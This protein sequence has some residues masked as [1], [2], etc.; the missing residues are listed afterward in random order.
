METDAPVRRLT[1]D[2]PAGTVT[3]F[4]SDIEGSTQLV[5]RLGPD[6]RQVL[7]RHGSIVREGLSRYGGI[8]IG[9][10]GDSFFAVFE[11]AP[12][13]VEATIW[14]QHALAE[15]PW[16]DMG[17]VRVRI[18]LH[19][20]TA[21]IGHD[22]YI[23]LDV[24]RGARISAAGHGG[25]AL[26]STTTRALA[27]TAADFL[28]LGDFYLKDLE[29]P[30]R[31][32]QI[33]IP[34]LPMSFPPIRSVGS[35]RNNL[36]ASTSTLVGR[37]REMAEISDLLDQH[38]LVT[39]SGPGGIGKT[40]L[41][42]EIARQQLPRYAHGV[43]MVD[44]APV[45]DER[46]VLP[47]IGNSIGV[48]DPSLTG[49][50]GYLGDDPTLLFIDNFE[51]VIKASRDMGTMLQ[52]ARG[53]KILATSQLPLRI[54]GERLYRLSPLGTD[55]S[56]TT[57]GSDAAKLFADRAQAVD[58]SFR[59]EDHVHAVENLV[60]VL[61]GLPLAVELAAAR[62]NLMS[63]TEIAKRLT[64][65]MGLLAGGAS[66]APER[67]RSVRAAIKWSYDLLAP[68]SQETLQRLSQFRGGMTLDAAETVGHIGTTD[69]L[70]TIA[71]LVDHGLLMRDTAGLSSSR[72][73][74]L[75][76]I[77]LFAEE[78]ALTS[79][80]L[81]AIAA[82][83]AAHFCDL[84]STAGVELEGERLPFWL[85]VLEE[86]FDNLR[87]TLGF[88]ESAGDPV[89]GLGILGDTWRFF[90]GKGH[91][92]ELVMWLDRFEALAGSS[93]KTP[94]RAKGLMAW[95][96]AVY[97]QG[98]A[99][100]AISH[101]EDAVA[102]AQEVG[103]ESLIAS[104][105]YGL[106]TS[107]IMNGDTSGWE[108]LSR[109]EEIFRNRNDIGGLAHVAAAK[110]FDALNTGEIK[111][112]GKHFDHAFELYSEAGHRLYAGQTSLGSAGVALEEGR[113]DDA[114]DYAR[115]G[116]QYGEILGDR[117]LTAW[118][119]EW[120]ATALVEA[121][122]IDRAAKLSGAASAAREK[123]G[124]GWTPLMIGVEDSESR[125]TRVLG[126]EGARTARSVGAGLTLDEAVELAKGT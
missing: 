74:M 51:Q 94:Q 57:S 65:G 23:G 67:H 33:A 91:L 61:D 26:V 2:L 111:G 22:N 98:D 30:E 80:A 93:S 17:A 123:L 36:P 34:G 121:G 11:S 31:L 40:R 38:R 90:Q 112:S 15:E 45:E 81:P 64:T 107:L 44:L 7:E 41:A 115:K 109:A 13:A 10:E 39:V 85:A 97:W 25:Q 14:V 72:F 116:L 47:V 48:T 3:F 108:P 16:P 28:D 60:G 105:F 68:V 125:L 50:A 59:L 62:I 46:L 87:A 54:A 119:I 12:A 89:S 24:H 122:D 1:T 106:A 35:T 92:S 58:P 63:P 100:A 75:E 21:E 20:G 83:H 42:L 27:S 66:D 9:T 126:E 76:P 110:A 49:I 113:I 55:S 32:Y 88:Y 8:E 118:S 124:G 52:A 101:Y 84:A 43:F 4:F 5:Q 117:F 120:V 69:A 79:G 103:D 86:E 71:D 114:L 19:T 29:E 6:Y 104:A 56:S 73:R 70:T 53:L 102:I 78:T 77:R 95:G 96:A 18:G 99:P 37:S 82:A